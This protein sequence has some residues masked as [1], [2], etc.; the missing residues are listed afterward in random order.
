MPAEPGATMPNGRNHAPNVKKSTPSSLSFYV[1]AEKMGGTFDPNVTR[2]RICVMDEIVCRWIVSRIV[3]CWSGS[4]GAEHADSRFF[5]IC[6]SNI[7]AA[8]KNES[9]CRCWFHRHWSLSEWCWAP[10]L[11]RSRTHRRP[12]TAPRLTP[13]WLFLCGCCAPD[14]AEP[15]SI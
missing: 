5:G 1:D 15:A 13:Q 4:E 8:G 6:C 3:H 11:S 2:V 14:R 9:S 12:V 10:H 7:L